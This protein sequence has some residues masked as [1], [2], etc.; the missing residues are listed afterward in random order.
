METTNTS[1]FSKT[2]EV[3]TISIG[4]ILAGLAITITGVSYLMYM[5]FTYQ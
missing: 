4:L 1:A 5:K 2:L 3:R